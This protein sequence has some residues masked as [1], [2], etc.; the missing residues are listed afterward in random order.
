MK[1]HEEPRKNRLLP[2]QGSE[3]VMITGYIIHKLCTE[4]NVKIAFLPRDRKMTEN[5]EVME[6]ERDAAEQKLKK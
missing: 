4:R 2:T 1:L 6:T 5:F 3:C